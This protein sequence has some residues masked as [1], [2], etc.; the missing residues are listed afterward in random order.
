MNAS[1]LTYPWK[2][3]PN[4]QVGGAHILEKKNAARDPKGGAGDPSAPFLNLGGGRAP[5]TKRSAPPRDE[6]T[7]PRTRS[8]SPPPRALSDRPTDG[9]LGTRSAR[10]RSANPGVNSCR[11]SGA[12]RRP[13]RRPA[14]IDSLADA[15][16]RDM[17][18]VGGPRPVRPVGA[19]SP[20]LRR[21]LGRRRHF[22]RLDA[23]LVPRGDGKGEQAR[24]RQRL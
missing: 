15:R 21:R 20:R 17:G 24:V 1:F 6:P 5:P 11:P 13:T 3:F 4:G 8:P 12:E 22:H 9:T 16:L 19:A 10:R 18:P 7:L 2:K 14:V 23:D